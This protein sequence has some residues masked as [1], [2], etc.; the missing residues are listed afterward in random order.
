MNLN[1]I[2][3]SFDFRK[4]SRGL[5]PD[6]YSNTLKQYH[7]LLWSKPLPSGQLF[8][9]DDQQSNSYLYHK[10]SVGKF[11][12]SSDSLITTFVGWK[13]MTDIISQFSKEENERFISIGYTLGGMII[14]PSNQISNLPT[15]NVV[16]GFNNKILDRF[17]LTLECIRLHYAK[18]NNPMQSTLMRY[19]K[20]FDLF[21][22]FKNYVNFF[23]LNDLVN[24]NYSAIKFFL[25][26]NNFNCP[27]LPQNINQ[28]TEY[29]NNSIEFIKRRNK[30]I[31]KYIQSQ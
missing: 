15:I 7:K 28:Y 19:K 22:N 5:D 17:D 8:L 16:R 13:R 20:F 25:V 18:K 27:A 12:L 31:D 10:S 3:I 14:F 9:L 4:D 29:R 23:L 26:S 6:K 24:N 11:Y 30:R 1:D 21:I 2:D